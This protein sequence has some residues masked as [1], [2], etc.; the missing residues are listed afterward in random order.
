MRWGLRLRSHAGCL[1]A[2]Q[3]HKFTVH[4]RFGYLTSS[5]VAGQLQLAALFA[6]TGSLL[7]EPA[8]DMTGA[9]QAMALVRSAWGA[10]PLSE[11]EQHQLERHQPL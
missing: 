7:P 9:Q 10:R 1:R 4:P 5:S 6:A 8:S 11:E 3:I 2:V